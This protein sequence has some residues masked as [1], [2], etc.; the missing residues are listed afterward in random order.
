[1]DELVTSTHVWVPQKKKK[2]PLEN[3]SRQKL[4]L[5]THNGMLLKRAKTWITCFVNSKP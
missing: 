4:F 1:M 2:K 5:D 3:F